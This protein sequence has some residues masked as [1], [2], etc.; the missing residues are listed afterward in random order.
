L[1]YQPPICC[2]K[3]TLWA[4]GTDNSSIY[5]RNWDGSN[6]SAWTLWTTGYKQVSSFSTSDGGAYLLLIGAN[7]KLYTERF[8]GTA[9][10]VITPQGGS[11]T[12]IGAVGVNVDD[13]ISQNVTEHTEASDDCRVQSYTNGPVCDNFG[14]CFWT[15]GV[16][17][18]E[19]IYTEAQ[20]ETPGAQDTVGWTVR[21]RAFQGVSCDSY[22]GGVN[23][24]TSCSPQPCQPCST[25]PCNQGSPDFC[26]NNNTKWY[27]CAIHGGQTQLGT[28][29]HQF[30][31]E[32]VDINTL[33]S[34]GV[35]WEAFYVGNGWVPDVSTNW[36]PPGVI[37]CSFACSGPGSV[38]GDNFNDPSPNGPMEFRSY[39]Y[40]AAASSCKR[41]VADACGNSGGQ[42]LPDS[43]CGQT[44]QA[45]DNFFWN[46]R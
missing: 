13:D 26:T 41:Y 36:C 45:N 17:L 32:H 25:L 18:A 24:H 22:P 28:S 46:R 5:Y 37:G 15:Q 38:D 33:S 21:N 6:W 16:N 11:R 39:D 12:W 1:A 14:N 42:L 30:N 34:S 31:D 35:I 8:T 44:S 27:C 23:W 2:A 19:I 43:P 10:A 9:W 29:G 7:N 4:V 20:A 3:M 40:C